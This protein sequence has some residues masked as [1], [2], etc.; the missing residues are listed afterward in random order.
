MVETRTMSRKSNGRA[1]FY[2]WLKP[3]LAEQELFPS[4]QAQTHAGKSH[5]LREAAVLEKLEGNGRLST[6]NWTM[7][8]GWRYG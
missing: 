8:S 3:E 5:L 6:E 4:Y 7:L 2:C 1:S